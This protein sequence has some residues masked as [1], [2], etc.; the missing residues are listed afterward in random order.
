MIK[1]QILLLFAFYFSLLGELSG[2]VGG[3]GPAVDGEE[4]GVGLIVDMGSREGKVIHGRVSMAISNFNSFGRDNQM[5]IV[6]HTRDSKGDPLLA[7]SS[8]FNLG[9]NNKVKVIFSAQKL[10]LEAKSLAEFGNNTKIPVIPIAAPY[11]IQVPL[12]NHAEVKGIIAFAE[13]HEWEKVILIYEDHNDNHWS[14]FFEEKKFQVAY[15]SSVAA[16]SEDEYIIEELHRLKAMETSVFVVH[17]EPVLAS[18][19]FVHAKRL[20]MA[21]QGYAWIVTS[22]C[23]NHLQNLK[24]YSSI[25]E[26]MQGFIGFRSYKMK[27]SKEFDML[28]LMNFITQMVNFEIVNVL[29]TEGERRVGFWT[30]KFTNKLSHGFAHGRHLFSSSGFETIIWPGGTSTIPKGRRMQTSS[31]TLRIAVP[32]SNGFPQLLKVDID[33]QA[34]ISFSGFCIEVFKAA[35]AGLEHKVPYEFVPFEYNNPTIGEAYSDLVYQVYLQKYD[36]AVGDITITSNRSLYVDFTLPFTDMGIGMVS[37][38][39]SKENQNLWI[40]LKPLTPGL[41]LTIVGV[42]VLSALFIWLI[43]R[44]ASVERQTRQSNGEIGR[45]FGFSFSIFVFAHWEKLSSNLSRSV[46]VLWMFVVFI[47]GSNYTATLTSMMTVQQIEFNSGKSI[48]GATGPVSQGAIGNLNFP[49]L[50]SKSIRLTSLEEYAKALSEGGKNGRVS[51]IIEE[52]PYINILRQKYPTRYSMVGH[53]MPVT[54]GFGFAFPKGSLMAHDISREIEKLRE[55]GMLQRLE[56]EWFKSPITNFDSDNTLDSVSSLTVR[57]FR[58]LFLINGIYL[59][60]ACFLF[61]TSLLYKNFHVMKE[62][63]RPEFVK[64]YIC[65]KFFRNKSNANAVHPELDN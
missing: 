60:I 2:Q 9:E 64:Q 19:I 50:H 30:G 53:V 35:M 39:T 47:L 63:R 16:S 41:W 21:S 8:A 26:N 56:N 10:T 11:L 15:K 58:G 23:M 14:D 6:L 65:M 28:Q 13:L 25:S 37:R 24:D 27:G 4:V 59:A 36:A 32:K 20:G 49:N 12:H 43:E 5:R 17:V 7:L 45:M 22:K 52:M 33:L 51:A 62:W 46:I 61:L 38:L 57:D 55:D 42:Y 29:G 18:R 44:P 31:K 40:F 1:N 3:L 34:N 54:N 48:I